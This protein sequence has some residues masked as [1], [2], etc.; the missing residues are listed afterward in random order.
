MAANDLTT[1]TDV[2]AWLGRSDTNSDAAL[3]GLITRASRQILS[4]IQRPAILPRSVSE[5]RKA[6]RACSMVL[7]QYPVIAIASLTTTCGAVSPSL[8]AGFT[9]EAWDGT[10]PG[11]HQEVTLHNVT[12]GGDYVFV[13]YQAGYQISGEPHL[14]ANG[15]ASVVAPYGAWASD[16]AVIYANGTPLALVD[17]APQQG[18]YA[19]D[20]LAGTYDFNSADNG[21]NVLISY[22]YVPADL[23][24]AAI[25]LTSEMF[26]YSQRIGE[27]THSLGG[28]ETVTFDNA[29]LDQFVESLLQPYRNMLPV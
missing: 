15:A 14:V 11:A 25:E 3:S 8:T 9:L 2:K 26:R 6:P 21:Q 13:D 24:Q 7:R 18:Q 27:K 17:A 22:G 10:P 4:Y 12:F 16:V 19:L 1:L 5:V 29:R 23:A 20:A 28:N